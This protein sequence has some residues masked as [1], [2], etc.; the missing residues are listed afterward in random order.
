M[1]FQILAF[2]HHQGFTTIRPDGKYWI[3]DHPNDHSDSP[4]PG[5]TLDYMLNNW[6]EDGS[7]NNQFLKIYSVR[8]L[9][10]GEIFTIGDVVDEFYKEGT[11]SSFVIDDEFEDGMYV[12][13]TDLPAETSLQII[14]KV[15]KQ[16]H[17]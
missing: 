15:D 3:A 1:S 13:F 2:Q 8:R 14:R 7:F 6:L 4:E 12:T 11:I 10:D 9:S 17:A 5:A 16:L